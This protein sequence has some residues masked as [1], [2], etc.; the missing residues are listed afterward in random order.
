MLPASKVAL[1]EWAVVVQALMS[2]QQLVLLK[3]GG[4]EVEDEQF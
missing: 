4:V 3:K 1:K 2:C